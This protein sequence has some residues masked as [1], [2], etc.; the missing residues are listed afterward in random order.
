MSRSLTLGDTAREAMELADAVAMARAILTMVDE[1]DTSERDQLTID[2]MEDGYDAQFDAISA[3][4]G[5][6]AQFD[7]ISAHF[8]HD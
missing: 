2:W 3:H 7:A 5:H 1:D 8:G 4:F 6:D